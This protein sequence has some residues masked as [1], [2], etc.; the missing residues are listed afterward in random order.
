MAAEL[1]KLDMFAQSPRSEAALEFDV[2]EFLK[3][4]REAAEV[5]LTDETLQGLLRARAELGRS[6]FECFAAAAEEAAW[7]RLG[8]MAVLAM[9]PGKA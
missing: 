1:M 2:V 8:E 9:G 6:R 3:N 7:P 4:Q 5:T